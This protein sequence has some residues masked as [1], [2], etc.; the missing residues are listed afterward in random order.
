MVLDFVNEQQVIR[1]SFQDYYQRTELEGA[2]DPN[3]LYNLKYTL[4]Q[5]HVFT[6]EDVEEFVQLFV[7]KK[8]KSDRLQPFFQRIVETGY[9]NLA[10]DHKGTA[11]YERLKA[12]AKNLF[13]KETARYVKQY[14]F[15]SQIMTFTD[16][17][18]EKFYLFAKLLLRQL[19]YEKQTLPLEVVEMIDMDKL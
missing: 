17:A 2:T 16:T 1:A 12:E 10:S 14:S 11:D 15:I 19:P 4:E 7:V 3:K 9:E 13:R 5:M 6:P 18:L 8:V